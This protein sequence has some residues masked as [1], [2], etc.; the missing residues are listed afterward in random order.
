MQRKRRFENA[1]AW[2]QSSVAQLRSSLT[3]RSHLSLIAILLL[4]LTLRLALWAQPLHQPANDEVEYI[5]VAYD[6]LAG[7]GWQFY[8]SYHWLRAPLYSLFL[9]ASLRLFNGD[10]YLAALPNIALSVVLV[11]LVYALT[12]ELGRQS[13]GAPGARTAPLVAA[14]IAALLFTFAAFASL[15]MS[16]MLFS[17]LFS[18][19]LLL[20]LR[21][22]RQM[23]RHDAPDPLHAYGLPIAVGALLGLAILTRSLPL[24]F[25]PV[26][27]VWMVYAAGGSGWRPRRAALGGAAAVLLFAG[28]TIAP[29]TLR[30]CRAY[31]SCILVET[32]LSYNLWAFSEPREDDATIFA[33]LE[34]ISNPA[35]RADV[36]TR[37]GLERLREDP[38]ILARKL[39]PNWV[40][41]WSVKPIEDRFLLPDYVADPPPLVFLGALLADDALYH[42]ILLAGL[43]G[44]GAALSRR[45]PDAVLLALWMAYV[46]GIT[47][48]THG[49]GRYRH[50]LLPM[51]IPYAALALSDPGSARHATP[52]ETEA[53]HPTRRLV[54]AASYIF[55][56]LALLTALWFYPWNW[57]AAGAIRSVHRL[58]G[59]LARSHGDLAGAETAY[60]NAL[61]ADS[62]PDGWIA[63]GNVHRQRG[64]TAAA[65]DAYRIAWDIAPAYI[66]ASARLGDLY[67]S[68]GQIERARAAFIGRYASEQ[69]VLDWSWSN[70]A[71]EP[72]TRIAIGDGL[73]FGYVGGV[74]PA[75]TLRGAQVRW[76]GESAA[77]R[78]AATSNSARVLRL[79]IAAPHPDA[80]HITANI[81][82]ADHCQPL[83]ITPDWRVVSLI[84]P[85]SNAATQIVEIRS[86]TFVAADGRSLGVLL[87]WAVIDAEAVSSYASSD[88]YQTMMRVLHVTLSE[89]EGSQWP[90]N[91][92]FV[93][94]LRMTACG[95][96]NIVW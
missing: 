92:R 8:D 4:A 2:I 67:R 39:L 89:G 35:E 14:L 64:E 23:H 88:C 40:A 57:A 41:L 16:E 51:L 59:D 28:L 77:L 58:A 44:L 31:G 33:T 48:V 85:P 82:V 53:S 18:A 43:P 29:W 30:N 27:T 3:A 17:V 42:L 65:E 90:G 56:G 69:A 7:K 93:A 10:L 94:A 79:R 5:Q 19:A 6:L 81:C 61:E 84:L 34:N 96:S 22:R 36:A 87:D 66:P 46:I 25:L 68:T 32:G 80:E 91:L 70:L 95:V 15:Y 21:W 26:L 12:G 45:R 11:A 73:D 62:T 75:E 54:R 49:E 72:A 63:L 52:T 55:A 60:R 78:L 13:D 83:S 1:L 37:R 86:P 71:P 47:L 24:L 50:F 20:L 38:A 76:T 9:A 74:Y